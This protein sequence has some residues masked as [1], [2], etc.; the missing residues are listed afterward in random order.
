MYNE[1]DDEQPIEINEADILR[2]ADVDLCIDEKAAMAAGKVRLS[3]CTGRITAVGSRCTD[4]YQVGDE[5]MVPCTAE[6]SCPING[7]RRLILSNG[8]WIKAD[9][10]KDCHWAWV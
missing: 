4:R 10:L 8:C 9:R 1:T 2:P 5:I 7:R 3:V 6:V